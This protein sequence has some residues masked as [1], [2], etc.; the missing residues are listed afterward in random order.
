MG[1]KRIDKQLKFLFGILPFKWGNKFRIFILSHKHHIKTS[2]IIKYLRWRKS[3]MTVIELIY[4]QSLWTSRWQ[5]SWGHRAQGATSSAWCSTFV[6]RGSGLILNSAMC[7]A[8]FVWEISMDCRHCV[9]TIPP[10]DKT[11]YFCSTNTNF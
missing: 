8:A 2:L 6:P 1:D 9:H 3:L 5:S 10:G 11:L 4:P 7:V